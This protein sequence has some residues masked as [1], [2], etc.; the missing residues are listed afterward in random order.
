MMLAN[1]S[2]FSF[3][4][5][6]AILEF[7]WWS[8]HTLTSFKAALL[9]AFRPLLTCQGWLKKV[10]CCVKWPGTCLPNSCT[11]RN[12][13]F[14]SPGILFILQNHRMW[15]TKNPAA[16]L[17]LLFY[18]L[19]SIYVSSLLPLGLSLLCLAYLHHASANKMHLSSEQLFGNWMPPL[20][21]VFVTHQILF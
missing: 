5:T 18:P 2:Y 11:S 9:P 10:Q 3:T 1:Q 20:A 15:H 8:P 12:I 13:Q 14:S 21:D 7:P 17:S 4:T 6:V 19:C 16:P